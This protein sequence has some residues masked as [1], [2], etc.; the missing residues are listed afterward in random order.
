MTPTLTTFPRK[1]VRT[2]NKNRKRGNSQRKVPMTSMKATRFKGT[3]ESKIVNLAIV[4][5]R[6]GF[7]SNKSRYSKFLD[8]FV[9]TDTKGCNSVKLVAATDGKHLRRGTNTNTSREKVVFFFYII[10]NKLTKL[11]V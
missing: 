6:T 5:K 8:L 2:K 10:S 9:P 11:F 7:Q 1:D 3:R 4:P